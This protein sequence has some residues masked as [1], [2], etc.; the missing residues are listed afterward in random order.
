MK[1]LKFTLTLVA[2]MLFASSVFSQAKWDFKTKKINDSISELQLKVKLGDGWHIYSQYTKGTELPIVFEFEKSNDYQRIGKVLEPKAIAEYDK[3]AKDTTK[4]FGGTVLFRQKIKVR[5]EK[6]FKVKGSVNFQL[7]EKGSCIPPEDVAFSFDVKG[8]PKASQMTE[9]ISETETQTSTQTQADVQTQTSTTIQAQESK[10]EDNSMLMVFLISL[11]AGLLTLVTPCVFPMVPMT[12]SFF[13]KGKKS[14]KQGLKEAFF[15]GGSIIFM[16]AVIGL[17]LTLLLG[18]DAMYLIS[19]H[20]VPNMLFFIIF[21]L[22]A[23]SFF[24]MF[25]ITLPSSWINKSDKNADKGGYLGAFFIALTTVLVSFSCTGPILGAA[26][27]GVASSSTNSLV[28]LIS[29]IGFSIGFALPFTLLAMFPQMLSKM[30]SGSWLNTT[31]IVFGFL[32]IALGL[33]FLSMADLSANWGLLDRETY[34]VLWIIIFTLLGFYLLGKLKFKGDNDLEQIGVG[35]LFLSII[36]F[37]FA[38]YMIP[39]LWGAPLKAISGYVPPMTTQD[40]NIER[41]IVENAGNV[42]ST[43]ANPN[44]LPANRKYTDQLH[45]P[46]GFEGFFDL[47]EAKAYAKQVGKPIFIDFTGKTCANCREME[48]YVW[49][50]KQ[51]KKILTQ[52]YVMVAL[53]ADA[54]FIKLPENEWVTLKDGTVAKTLGKKNH[55]YQMEHFNANAQ[56]LY[57]L[58][59]ADGKVLNTPKGYDRNVDNFIKFL[60][61]GKANFKK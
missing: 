56:P 55:N 11:G 45:F 31:K 57:V 51:V 43:E 48:Y 41:S 29:M 25:E 13:M 18:K 1:Q 27:M 46:T 26:L 21:M 17:V 36:T 19:T 49:E 34:L 52:D 35:R 8:N 58:M 39:G 30:K 42:S 32:E 61:E 10:K 37:S 47:E 23:F 16:F 53:Y 3:Y 7:C 28:F 38:L 44:S 24:G 50:D 9:V 2:I 12:I 33:K 6:D 60:E 59:S 20:W 4:H 22:F 5:S 15:F 14:K 54:N 40:F